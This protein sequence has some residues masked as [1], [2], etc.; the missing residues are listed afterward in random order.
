MPNR[1]TTGDRQ[2]P[3]SKRVRYDLLDRFPPAAR[4]LGDAVCSFNPTYG[5]GMSVAA[6]EAEH[7]GEVLDAG[8]LRT[9]GPRCFARSAATVDAAWDLTVGNDL[10][11]PGGRG[12]ADGAAALG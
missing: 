2:L 1:W 5:Q 7:L 8:G 12:L 6:L 11:L 9:I 3:A 4:G 10:R